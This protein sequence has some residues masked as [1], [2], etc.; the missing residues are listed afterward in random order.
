MNMSSLTDQHTHKKLP[1]YR[2]LFSNT[3]GL[4]MAVRMVFAALS[5]QGTQKAEKSRSRMLMK[6]LM[7]QLFELENID[8]LIKEGESLYLM[9][10]EEIDSLFSGDI[11]E[12]LKQGNTGDRKK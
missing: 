5:L 10:E 6:S 1:Q 8:V 4:E 7:S 11:Y 9:S 2:F 12:L 3:E